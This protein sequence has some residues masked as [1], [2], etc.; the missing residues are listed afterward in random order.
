MNSSLT[1][2]MIFFDSPRSVVYHQKVSM[3]TVEGNVVAFDYLN[4]RVVSL[5]NK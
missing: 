5:E 3:I 1:Y 4:I 2:G